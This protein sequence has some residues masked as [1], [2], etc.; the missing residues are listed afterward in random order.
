[1]YTYFVMVFLGLCQFIG[2][3]LDGRRKVLLLQWHIGF[4]DPFEDAHNW[5]CGM[6][7]QVCACVRG[8]STLKYVEAGCNQ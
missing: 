4:L 2:T 1:M 6:C 3:H 7:V 5:L 8:W